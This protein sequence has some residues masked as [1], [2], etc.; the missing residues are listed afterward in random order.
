MIILI[1]FAFL[2]GLVTILSPCILPILPIVLSGSI[3]SGK[4]RPLG[5]VTGFIISF[6]FFTLALSSI[7]KAS[8]VSADLLRN[9]SVVIITLFGLSLLIPAWQLWMEKLFTNVSKFTPK[10]EANSGFRG[11]VILGLSLGLIW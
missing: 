1:V 8:G 3:D 6:T 4:K 11:G 7:V 5:I 9:I 10:Q 2:A